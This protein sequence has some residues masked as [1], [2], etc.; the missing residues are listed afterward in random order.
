MKKILII[1]DG[2]VAEHFINRVIDTYTSENIYYVVQPKHK[3]YKNINASRFKFYEFDPTSLYKLANLLKMEFAQAIV[4]MDNPLDTEHTI[5]NIRSIKKQLRIIVLNKWNLKNEDQNVVLI[6]SNEILS[7]RLLNY[8]PN[9]PVIAQNVGMGEGEI[10]EVLV[11]FGSSFVYKHIGVIEQKEWRIVAIYRNK[12]LIMPSRRRMIQPNDLLL[13]VGDPVVLKSVY[14]AIK[15]ELGQFPE[16]F[17]SNLYLYLDM[18][19]INFKTTE[20]LVS[21]TIFAHKK[22]GHNLIIRIVNPNNI[23][24]IWKIKEFRD[25]TVIIDIDYDGI[26]QKKNFFNDIKKYHVG[27]VIVPNE[28]FDDYNMRTTLY[29]AHVPVLKIANKVLSSVKDASIILGDNRDL[30]K[31]SSTIFDISAQMH[32]NIELYNYINEHQEAKEQVIEHY[33]NLSTI[34]SKNIKIIK[35]SENPIKKLKNKNDFIQILPF[36]KKL[37]KKKIYSLLSTDSE[38]LYH[39]LDDNHQIFIPVQI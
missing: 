28:I 7:S 1:S 16:P 17:G 13:L 23:D 6:N 22:L 8:L 11:P 19:L 3:I 25:E 34:F 31:I 29:E 18:D 36:T 5:K 12:K 24:L 37:T 39:K 26:N 27:L 4:V 38:R 15:R 20:K 10:M 35:D 33:Y 2:E 9:V 30:E 21:R 32:L 14:I